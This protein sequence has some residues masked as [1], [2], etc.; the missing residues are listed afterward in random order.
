VNAS[1]VWVGTGS[2]VGQPGTV[3]RYDLEGGPARQ[4]LSVREGVGGLLAT[5]GTIWVVKRDTNKLARMK[6]DADA[7]TD[8]A[9]LPGRVMNLTYAEDDVWAV[10]EE[11]DTVVRVG[12][13]DGRV[14]QQAAGSDP[15][16][17]L[18]VGGRVYVAS[19][20][21]NSVHVLDP[22]TLTPTQD[23]IGVGVNPY[24]LVADDR[25]IWV[26]GLGDNTLTEIR[27][28]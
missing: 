6:P 11:Q 21:T 24:A 1:G 15:T 9:T 17:A 20:N 27:Y 14:L 18:E 19:R 16:Q 12:A 28:R 22:E 2:A 10:L 7:L 5:P 13:D 3:L 4:P 23:P 26:T 25:S 8:W